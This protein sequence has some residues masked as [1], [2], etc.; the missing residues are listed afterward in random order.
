MKT[1]QSKRL[2]SGTKATVG[3]GFVKLDRE[4]INIGA[5]TAAVDTNPDNGWYAETKGCGDV[6][7][8]IWLSEMDPGGVLG[9]VIWL[10]KGPL[11]KTPDP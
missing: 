5:A 8:A 1:P 11:I 7:L 6:G 3:N 10:P 9:L 2:N 4:D